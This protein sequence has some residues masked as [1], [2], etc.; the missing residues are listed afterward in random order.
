MFTFD[1][2]HRSSA[3]VAPVKEKGDLDNLRDNFA[4]SKIFL[5]AKLMNMAF[6][7]PTPQDDTYTI[8][9]LLNSLK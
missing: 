6:I 8:I 1:R 7:T 3:A 4:R 9:S 2:C 5:T